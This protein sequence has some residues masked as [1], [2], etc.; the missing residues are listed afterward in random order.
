MSGFTQ[1]LSNLPPGC[2]DADIERE[3]EDDRELAQASGSA[4]LEYSDKPAHLPSYWVV[5]WKLP[6]RVERLDFV[7]FGSD[8]NELGRVVAHARALAD[9]PVLIEL[10]WNKSPSRK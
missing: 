1:N 5:R 10:N 2:T 9:G 4:V 8:T 7:R 6:R 3:Q